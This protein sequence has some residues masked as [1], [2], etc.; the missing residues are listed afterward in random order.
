MIA[1]P[2]IRA[3]LTLSAGALIAA[4]M[5]CQSSPRTT[6]GTGGALVD[7]R[8]TNLDQ[9]PLAIWRPG[10]PEPKADRGEEK[11]E[12][13]SPRREMGPPPPGYWR[14]VGDEVPD[15]KPDGAGQRSGPLDW[16]F[17]GPE[18]IKEEYWSGNGD[19]SGRVVSIAPHPVDPL[20]AYIGS[21]SGGVWK[22]VDAGETWTPITDQL[23]SL[24]QGV[25]AVSLSNPDTVMVATGEYTTG[26][27]GAGVFRS[28]D[29]GATWARIGSSSEAGSRC[30]GLAIHP[31]NPDIVHVT[32]TL[33]YRRTLDAGETWGGATSG[34][35]AG[36][37][38]SLVMDPQNPDVIYVARRSDGIYRSADAGVSFARLG[39]GLPTA[40]FTRIVMAIAPSDPTVLYAAFINFSAGLEGLYKTTSSGSS[41]QKLTATPNFPT[42]QGWYDCF[43]GV[44]PTDPETVYCGGVSP[45]YG[46]GGVIKTVDGGASWFDITKYPTGWIHPDM[47]AV[48]FGPTGTVW[49]GCD[50]GVW[51]SDV[52][53][54]SFVNCNAT[55]QVTQHYHVALH[56]SDPNLI[57]GGTQDNGTPGKFD[58]TLEWPQIVEGDGG[59]AAFDFQE[60]TRFYTTYVYLSTF[61]ITPSGLDD[62]TGP[63]G[64]PPTETVNFIA[65]LVID[66]NDANTLLG[67]TWRVWRTQDARTGATWASIS[68]AKFDPGD[69]LNAIAV[70]PGSSDTIY[71]GSSAGR[72]LVTRDAGS[73]LDRSEGLPVG[74]VSD[75]VVQP[76]S[77]GT[78]YVAYF[79]AT[80]PRILK[81]TNFGEDWVDASA[82]LPI[83]PRIT[84][85]AIDWGVTP[86]TLLAGTGSGIYSSYD[87]GATWTR[88]GAE[89]PNV[90][91]GDLVI[92][93]RTI[94]AATY[95][96]GMW[97]A[98]LDGGGACEAPA[99]VTQPESAHAC[100]GQ[101]VTLS[102]EASGTSLVYEWRRSGVPVPGGSSPTLVFE[103][104]DAGD[105]GVY[106][107]HITNECGVADSDSVSVTVDNLSVVAQ[108]QNIAVCDGTTIAFF[109]FDVDGA[110]PITYQWRHNGIDIPGAT[111]ATLALFAPG[112]DDAG[113]YVCVAS[114]S[115]GDLVS[116]PAS[117]AILT[118]PTI[119][120]TLPGPCTLAPGTSVT[121]SVEATG[122]EPL[123]Y[124]WLLDGEAIPGATTDTYVVPV[125][126]I[127]ASYSVAVTNTCGSVTAQIPL[128]IGCA[129][130]L[131]RDGVVDFIDYLEF[132]NFYDS[133]D[134]AAD[135]NCD[136]VIDF[137]DYLEFLNHF[138]A[139]C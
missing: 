139:G 27:T 131:N 29:A 72:V 68:D 39:G 132:L 138:D 102:V 86:P 64:F 84:A 10:D 57:L 60:P 90:N 16:V 128:V 30:S 134:P 38:S 133:L 65:P 46:E 66:P 77:P 92:K 32:S 33:G 7:A 56:P 135:I 15:W 47:H 85:L 52:Q 87:G 12:D 58:A 94:V 23:A 111:S 113:V 34:L 19:A 54:L 26:S 3:S 118:G 115:C 48:A 98:N 117:L 81:T 136:G 28:D 43:V 73:W 127:G 4:V 119:L 70:A 67:G 107:C 59:F 101:T 49:I 97:R 61:R 80:G 8:G 109:T 11:E 13:G 45:D 83:G 9:V 126:T 55:L 82:G 75:I 120:Y 53:G 62:I 95:G 1:R 21:A 42:P 110:G 51:K 41:W 129:A 14:I 100:I 114:N 130:D 96:R 76:G 71:A 40:G 99:V 36:D 31:L 108:P 44:D 22:T 2:L 112:P 37:C 78:A 124:Q 106:S 93:G 24:N 79:L 25:V 121:L 6:T 74:E 20:I 35:P 137:G 18:P 89:F 123:Q 116:N 88:D 122:T 63:W 17:I 105:E 69:P 50:G 103:T 91:V 5:A 104:L 125:L